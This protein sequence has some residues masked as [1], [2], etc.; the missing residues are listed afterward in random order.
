M[1]S[2]ILNQ[3]NIYISNEI[4]KSLDEIRNIKSKKYLK[5]T[6]TPNIYSGGLYKY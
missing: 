2:K 6:I 5:L 1:K 4:L 3:L